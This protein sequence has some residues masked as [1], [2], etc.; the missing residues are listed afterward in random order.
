[1]YNIYEEVTVLFI[2]MGGVAVGARPRIPA[3][4]FQT[5]TD[6]KPTG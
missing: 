1:M 3:D 2:L 4:S 5:R 6:I